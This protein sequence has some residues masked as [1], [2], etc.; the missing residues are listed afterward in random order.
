MKLR[1]QINVMWLLQGLLLKNCEDSSIVVQCCDDIP[2]EH[3][4]GMENVRDTNL[5]IALTNQ[6]IET[7]E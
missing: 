1:V 7:C 3:S 6:G 2:T 5:S 4:L